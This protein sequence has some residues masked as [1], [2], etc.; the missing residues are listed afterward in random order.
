MQENSK[1][2]L[3]LSIGYI[4]YLLYLDNQGII[5]DVFTGDVVSSIFEYINDYSSQESAKQPLE[6]AVN[7][8]MTKFGV[9]TNKK[10]SKSTA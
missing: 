5:L 1:I 2:D 10:E 7:W 9:T 6:D 3:E 8:L 4:S